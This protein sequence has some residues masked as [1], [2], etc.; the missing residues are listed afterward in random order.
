VMMPRN[1]VPLITVTMLNAYLP[2]EETPLV[3]HMK[4]R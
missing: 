3:R 4:A 1:F 2:E